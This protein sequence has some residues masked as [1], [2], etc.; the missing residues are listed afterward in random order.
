[1][2]RNRLKLYVNYFLLIWAHTKS[3]KLEET[4]FQW[5]T[6]FSLFLIWL[7]SY[8]RDLCGAFL[9]FFFFFFGSLMTFGHHLLPLCGKKY[10]H[11]ACGW[12]KK[13]IIWVLNN[14]RASKWW[15]NVHFWVN[16]PSAI[17]NFNPRP[18]ERWVRHGTDSVESAGH[19]IRP[20]CCPNAPLR[21][22]WGRTDSEDG[23]ARSSGHCHPAGRAMSHHR[24][25]LHADAPRS[26]QHSPLR[27]GL[28]VV[29]SLNMI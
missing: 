20:F 10:E 26:H 29:F 16:D 9:S 12:W 28:R 17:Q 5:I 14:S 15:H 22:W 7:Q 24:A 3:H 6:H 1:M 8:H 25:Q 23:K 4:N 19:V 2:D 11:P 27:S 18:W 13:R 21:L